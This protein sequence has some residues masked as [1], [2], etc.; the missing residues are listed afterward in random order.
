MANGVVL[1]GATMAFHTY[2]SKDQ[3]TLLIVKV[4]AADGAIAAESII[5]HEYFADNSHNGPFNLGNIA[6][7]SKDFLF[8]RTVSFEIQPNGDDVWTFDSTVELTFSDGSTMTS[9]TWSSK[10]DQGH[11]SLSVWNQSD[12]GV[13]DAP[14]LQ[15][16]AVS[17]TTGDDDKN[18]DTLLTVRL[19]TNDDQENVIAQLS[20]TIGTFPNGYAGPPYGLKVINPVSKDQLWGSTRLII[21]IDPHGNDTWRFNAYFELTFF[22]GSRVK[23]EINGVELNEGF[24]QTKIALWN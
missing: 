3:D 21:R 20:D 8:H 5:E 2:D 14:V 19:T 22:D 10:L 6:A 7:I 16:A 23:A 12:S 17:F 15:A 4:L 1:Q 24:R 13:V 18:G 11:R 9:N